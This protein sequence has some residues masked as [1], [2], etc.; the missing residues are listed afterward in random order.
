MPTV[1]ELS[2]VATERLERRIGLRAAPALELSARR[3][4]ATGGSMDVFMALRWDATYDF[5]AIASSH[6][7]SGYVKFTEPPEGTYL[8][9][10]HFSATRP[11]SAS[12]GHGAR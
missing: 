2:E 3:P 7:S 1:A 12:T 5:F 8:V 6:Q 4:Y 10:V 11:R 9:A